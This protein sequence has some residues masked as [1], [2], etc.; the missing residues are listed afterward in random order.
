MKYYPKSLYDIIKDNYDLKSLKII[1]YF[2]L[3]GIE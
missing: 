1:F 2:I 3:R